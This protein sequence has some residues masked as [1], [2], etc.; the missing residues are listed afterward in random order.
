MLICDTLKQKHKEK[1]MCY[2]L[3]KI[4]TLLTCK[5]SVLR[6]FLQSSTVRANETVLLVLINHKHYVLT[7]SKFQWPSVDEASL[8]AVAFVVMGKFRNYGLVRRNGVVR[9]Q[10][11]VMITP[12]ILM[13]G[14]SAV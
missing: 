1:K 2:W 11:S 6:S 14:I 10:K 3:T 4:I 12:K 7:G 13:A 9:G 8:A 5:S